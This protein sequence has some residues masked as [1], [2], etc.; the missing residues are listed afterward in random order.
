MPTLKTTEHGEIRVHHRQVTRM[1]NR[2][3]RLGSPARRNAYVEKAR[4]RLAAGPARH[5]DAAI[6][7]AV[8]DERAPS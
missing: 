4:R 1:A 6:V 5:S 3:W 2:L 7:L 8:G